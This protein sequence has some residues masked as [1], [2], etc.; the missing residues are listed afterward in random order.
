MLKFEF[1][2]KKKPNTE[3][4]SRER[5]HHEEKEGNAYTVTARC[6]TD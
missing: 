1:G 2:G 3:S 6:A 4:F 5:K